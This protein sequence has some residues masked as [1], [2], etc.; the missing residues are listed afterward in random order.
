LA[1]QNLWRPDP[2]LTLQAQPEPVRAVPASDD[3]RWGWLPA[4]TLTS[5]LALVLAAF[6]F[7]ASRSGQAWATTLYWISLL[8]IFAPAALRLAITSIPRRERIG[9]IVVVGLAL[10]TVKVLHSP[11]DFT[12]HDEFLH[13]RTAAD[14]LSSQHLFAENTIL[15][16]SPLYPGLEIVTTAFANLSG[17]PIYLSAMITLGIGRLVFMLALYLLY[18]QVGHSAQIG[19]I[20]ALVYMANSNFLYFDSQFSYETLSLPIA[21][22]VLCAVLYRQR[23]HDHSR[24]R[25]LALIL[26]MLLMVVITHHLTAYVLVAFLSLWALL[27][28]FVNRREREWL[29]VGITAILSMVVVIGWMQ[30]TGNVTEGYLGPVFSGGITELF[31]LILSDESGRMLFQGAAGQ[32]SP[33]WERIVGLLSVVFILA[34]LP[35]GVVQVWRSPFGRRFRDAGVKVLSSSAL[36]AWKRYGTNPIAFALTLLVLV[37]P[38]MQGFRLTASGWEIANR[39]SEFVFWATA[40]IAAIGVLSLRW[41]RV[42]SLWIVGFIVWATVIFIGGAISGWPPWARLPGSYLVSADTRSIEPQSIAAA[43]WTGTYLNP[44]DRI[45]SDR[46]NTL[47]LATYGRMRPVTHQYDHLYMSPVFASLEFGPVE[48]ALLEEVGLRYVLV[49]DRLS[50]GLPR[51][52]VYFEAG[53]PGGGQYAV[54]LPTAALTKFDRRPDISRIFDSGDIQIYDVSRLDAIP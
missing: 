2:T 39:S 38:A 29:D 20:A 8:L 33:S 13:W 6:A 19:S 37:Y 36:Q 15:T 17:L 22:A 42:R 4:L 16:V 53:E 44:A 47:L 1:R 5:A 50:T 21:T 52:G 48:R 28:V 30:F 14:I 40:F 24:S 46:I 41:S 3:A 43:Q 51:V 35:F 18:E 54:P 12:F 11:L 25:L 26:P 34:A 23:Q 27:A 45:A 10:Y 32:V 9:L 31:R 7:S 49:D